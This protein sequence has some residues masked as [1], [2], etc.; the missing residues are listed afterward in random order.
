MIVPKYN[1]IDT[2]LQ[3]QDRRVET[4]CLLSQIAAGAMAPVFLTGGPP[5]PTWLREEHCHGTCTKEH[6]L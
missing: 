2:A 3:H 1:S 6:L 5:T 4:D